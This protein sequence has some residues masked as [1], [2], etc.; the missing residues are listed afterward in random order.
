MPVAVTIGEVHGETGCVNLGVDEWVCDPG[1]RGVSVATGQAG[2]TARK[3]RFASNGGYNE[4]SR[5]DRVFIKAIG[6]PSSGQGAM[7][8]DV[9]Q[10]R[11]VSWLR[12]GLASGSGD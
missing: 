10:R 6:D 5:E 2:V 7:S 3:M 9:G 1:G 8:S 4:Y 12:S 11:T